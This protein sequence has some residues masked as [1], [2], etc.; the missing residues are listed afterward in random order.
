[1]EK[2]SQLTPPL[3]NTD[4]DRQV[5]A[6]VKEAVMLYESKS[7]GYPGYWKGF[8]IFQLKFREDL[9]I[10]ISEADK[11]KFAQENGELI[12]RVYGALDILRHEVR[13]SR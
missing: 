8:P 3:W 1:M 4:A 5:L 2:L 11:Q 10:E 9:G 13:M 6:R 7:S 12:A